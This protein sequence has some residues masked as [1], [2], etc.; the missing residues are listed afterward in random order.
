MAESDITYKIILLELMERAD[1]AMSNSQL[2]NFF[3]DQQYTD[4]F[5]VQKS[6]SRLEETGLATSQS[7]H[8][9]TIYSI[10]DEGSR[11]LELFRERITPAIKEDMKHY[12]ELNQI[13]MKKDSQ[14]FADYYHA[15]G[16]GYLVHV[17][18]K[19]NNQNIMDFTFRVPS[20]DQAEAICNNWRVHYEDVYE[21][22][23]DILV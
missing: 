3:L 17:K 16:G 6:I 15:T 11:T 2:T 4:Y 21:K 1:F 5:T 18:C 12:F 10:T 7:S 22:L 23:M 9:N 13:E 19:E 14:V 8:G 20:K